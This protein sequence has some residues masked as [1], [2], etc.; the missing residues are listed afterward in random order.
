MLATLA[1]CG[2]G[3]AGSNGPTS[4]SPDSVI[5]A[6]D[7]NGNRAN[8]VLSVDPLPTNLG[9]VDYFEYNTG[10]GILTN[11]VWN[12]QAAGNFAYSECV[13]YKGPASAKIWGW[14]WN[15]PSNSGNVFSYPEIVFG[16]KPW[17]PDAS[18]TSSLPKKISSLNTLNFSYDLTVTTNGMH[19]VAT[20][21]WLT[22]NGVAYAGLPNASHITT[23]FMIWTDGYSWSPA[24]TLR[25][26]YTS[27]TGIV[28]E[29]WFTPFHGDSSGQNSI[30]WKYV[31]Y[32]ATTPTLSTTLDIKSILN[33]AVT[34]GFVSANDYVSDVE[35][36]NE[37]MSGAG[38]TWINSISLVVQ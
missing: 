34:R 21:M 23:E 1:A 12:K 28:Y 16:W 8:I 20:S 19:N 26:H 31:A 35:L 4:T 6:N 24:G 9:C 5:N 22:D 7:A 27:P 29:V 10:N 2:G 38:Q 13:T 37:V 11:N 3:G 33:D 15:W 17:N 14:S 18:T 25:G 36:G 30:V 32:R